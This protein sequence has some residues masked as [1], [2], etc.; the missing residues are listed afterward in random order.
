MQHIKKGTMTE[1]KK[2]TKDELY[3]IDDILESVESK[4]RFSNLDDESYLINHIRAFI[5]LKGKRYNE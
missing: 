2:L 1:T 4:L 5:R 3:E